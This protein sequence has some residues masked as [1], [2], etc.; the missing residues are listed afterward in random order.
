MAWLDIFCPECPIQ[1]NDTEKDQPSFQPAALPADPP[2]PEQ[3]AHARRM[4]VSCPVQ[5]RRLHCWHCSRCDKA[6]S[7]AAWRTRR[8]DV[9]SFRH[10]ES[11]Y[12]LHLLDLLE[13]DAE[14]RVLQ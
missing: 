1:K 14:K 9:E 11:P 12:S 2:T 6:V 8:A 4:L 10:R 5:R 13:M 7:C 3:I